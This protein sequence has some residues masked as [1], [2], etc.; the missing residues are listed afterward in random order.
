MKLRVGFLLKLHKIDKHLV[1]LTKKKK[2]EDTQ[3]IKIRNERGTLQLILQ[4]LKGL[5]ANTVN[6]CM[7]TNWKT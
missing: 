2:I 1:R 5:L 7:P 3:I 6:N 4:K